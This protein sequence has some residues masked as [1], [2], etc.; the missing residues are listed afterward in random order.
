MNKGW[1][2]GFQGGMLL[3]SLLSTLFKGFVAVIVVIIAVRIII[4]AFRKEVNRGK[5]N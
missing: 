3:L 1:L 5:N 4:K 2:T